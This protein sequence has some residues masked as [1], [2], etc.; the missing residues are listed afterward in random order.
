[1]GAGYEC[2]PDGRTIALPAFDADRS[3]TLWLVPVDGG[4][5]RPLLR[6]SPPE[7]IIGSL[8]KWSKDGKSVLIA[9]GEG[10]MIR[11]ARSG[12]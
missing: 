11:R 6:A 7:M 8:A 5:P 9:R 1:M 3:T 12:A 2:S 10:V 4:E